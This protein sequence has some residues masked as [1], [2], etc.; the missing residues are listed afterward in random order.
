MMSAASCGCCERVTLG[1]LLEE[2]GSREGLTRHP[3]YVI[4]MVSSH[5]RR[6]VSPDQDGWF[7]NDDYS[8]FERYDTLPSGRVERVLFDEQGAGAVVRLW[9]TA[10]DKRG[11]LRFYFD[12][13][14]EAR[15]VVPAYDMMRSELK[16]SKELLFSHTSYQEPI[17]Q[18]GGS[19]CYL[20]IPFA[21][22]LKITL[23]EVVSFNKNYYQIEYRR[24]PKGAK[25]ESFHPEKLDDYAEEIAAAEKAL[26][27][28]EIHTANH[29]KKM[30]IAGGQEETLV[31]PEGENVVNYL[32]IKTSRFDGES[33]R[34]LVVVGSFDGK[35]TIWCPLSDFAAAGM[36]APRSKCH[37]VEWDAE[38]SLQLW[39]QMPYS[40]CAQ[41]G[42]LNLGNEAVEIDMEASVGDYRWDDN[43][44]YFHAS[45]QSRTDVHLCGKCGNPVTAKNDEC[46]DERTFEAKGG[47]GVLVGNLLSVFNHAD[48]WYG[49]GDAKIWVDDDT[50]PSILGTGLEDYYNASW[51]PL[52]LYYTPYGGAIRADLSSSHG[53]NAFLR[54]RL[55][56]AIPFEN[57]ICFD[58]EIMGWEDGKI[59]YEATTFWY[60]DMGVEPVGTSGKEAVLRPLLPAPTK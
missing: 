9:T 31:L 42:I 36:G 58:V 1:S 24:Y 3:E 29:T 48:K 4:K 15:W 28:K 53:Y 32:T 21:K 52:I 47:R 37:Y 13:E 14:S 23:E 38:G 39:W 44:L 50:F 2:M 41:I 57:N 27:E 18:I 34:K 59:D 6:S 12:G 11:T 19:S 30:L 22:G 16:L 8:G 17:E 45:W 26:A 56:D 46:L 60:G 54:T 51:A 40:R 10:L 43:S 33:M 7:A 20:P 5:D 55:L 25:V 49:E 35:Q